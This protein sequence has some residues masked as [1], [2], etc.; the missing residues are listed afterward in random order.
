[1][2][3]YPIHW[4]SN[5]LKLC[6]G[7]AVVVVAIALLQGKE[8]PVDF[9]AEVK[10]IINKH[11]ITCHGGVK[12]NGGFSLL[13]EE[14]AF[15]A[16][17]SGNPAIIRGDAKHSEFIRRLTAEDPEERMPYNAPPLS[18]KEINLLTRWIEQGAKWG[19]HWAY[20]LPKEVKVPR[21]RLAMASLFSFW[22]STPLHSDIDYFINAKHKEQGLSFS[23]EADRATLLRRLSLD[24]IGLPPSPEQVAA[25]INDK[26]TDAYERRVDS[27]LASPRF[28]ERWASWWLDIARYA[29]TKGYEKDSSREIWAYRDWVIKAFNRD[30]PFN[31]FTIEQLAGDLLP[32]A[33]KDQLIA[34][35]FHRNTMAND[36]GGTDDEEFRVAAVIDRVNTTYQ[37]WLSTTF[38][39]VQCH[40][41]TYD[42]IK[43]EEYYKSMAFFNNTR[44]EDTPGDYP[45]LRFYNKE[46]SVQ[47]AR[48]KQWVATYSNPEMAASTDRFLYTLEPKIHAHACDQLV[49]GALVDTKWLG[50]RNGG[51][52]RLPGITLGEDELFYMNYTTGTSGGLLEMRVGGLSGPLLAKVTLPATQGMETITIPI[53]ALKGKHDIYL[54]FKNPSIPP[55]QAVCLAEWMAFRKAL[56]GR[57]Q[58]GYPAVHETFLQLVNKQTPSVPILIEN[59]PEMARET[60]VFERGNWLVHGQAVEPDVPQSLHDF[61]TDA[62]RNRL[63]FA[64]WLVSE[65]NPLTARTLV[66]RLWAQ[67]FG[68]GI[69]EPLGDMG[70]QSDPP[71]HPELLDWLALQLM[72]EMDWSVKR[73]LKELVTSTTYRQSAVLT[74][75]LAEKDPN[76]H[77]YARGPRFRL[78][79]EQI[80]D[81]TLAV[82]G[83]LSTKM[84]GPSVMPYQ[85]EGV[86]MSVY[87]GE[88]WTKSE[89]EDQYRRGVYT[90]IKRT[91]PY[92]S[93]VT[94][95]ASSREVCLI[96]RITTNTPL[97][98]LTTLNDPVYLEAAVHLAKRMEAAGKG[99]VPQSIKTG[100]HLTVQKQLL[101]D[102]LV[103]LEKLYREAYQYYR[104]QPE[105]AAKLLGTIAGSK[106]KDTATAAYTVVANALLNLDEFLTKS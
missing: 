79:A 22:N 89:G 5:K 32:N 104:Q 81:Q 50:I 73:L 7:I 53:T 41:H 91:S 48:I 14:E 29:D 46:D 39:C 2:T 63:G 88:R 68:H 66:N 102:R 93:Y 33:S 37:A 97:Q 28:G 18:K 85:P 44:D 100:Y 19:E 58:P 59:P 47:A 99:D 43:F 25:F 34:T 10:P 21:S 57:D 3:S 82:S 24:L 83:L 90:F 80:R 27:L 60:H 78:S 95:D 98:A 94:F 6:I 106:E 11:C 87:S 71:T 92:P 23:P 96:D 64:Q 76:N 20:S 75:E 65:E 38:E 103:A 67:L 12:K 36:E 15:A 52:A 69:V 30:M 86:W 17:E 16:T 8:E 56:P 4:H 105:E 9:S 84:H 1:M 40:S 72:H 49:N 54:L 31:T 45:K 55:S 13:F 61:P 62:P 77:Y 101:P 74:T 51:S 26:Q 35:A 70:T 42:P